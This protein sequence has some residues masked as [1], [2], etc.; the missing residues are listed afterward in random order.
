MQFESGI[1]ISRYLPARGT[2]SDLALLDDLKTENEL[3]HST[4][5]L[6][7]RACALNPSDRFRSAGEFMELTLGLLDGF[8][9]E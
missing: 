9:L 1:S 5:G 2:A 8:L 3:W 4:A 7:R 6:V